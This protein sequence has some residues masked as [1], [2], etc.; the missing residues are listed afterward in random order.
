MTLTYLGIISFVTCISV[1][2]FQNNRD[3]DLLSTI[4]LMLFALGVIF[5]WY[6]QDSNKYQYRR[7]PLLNIG[8]LAIGFIALP[9][10]FF[11][12]RGFK[13]GLYTTSLFIIIFIAWYIVSYAGSYAA[14]YAF[15][16][17]NG[18]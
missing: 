1:Y 9:Y 17:S 6:V 3:I 13:G 11:R 2:V 12:T 5:W 15:P 10:Y 14:W 7:S 18:T 16:G 8:I 4:I